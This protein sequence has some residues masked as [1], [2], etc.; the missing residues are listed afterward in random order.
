ME[1]TQKINP[2]LTA[3]KMR[4]LTSKYLRHTIRRPIRPEEGRSTEASIRSRVRTNASDFFFIYC[5]QI[6]PQIEDSVENMLLEKFK[7]T[8]S[9][10]LERNEVEQA[11]L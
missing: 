10:P 11:Y 8:I 1:A 9:S 5:R 4:D 2:L 6:I 7:S 3:A